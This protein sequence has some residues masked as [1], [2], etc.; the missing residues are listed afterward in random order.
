MSL[1]VRESKLVKLAT[2][3]TVNKKLDGSLECIKTTGETARTSRQACKIMSEFSVTRF[4]GIGVSLA[5]R[6]S[7]LGWIVNKC[8]VNTEFVTEILIRRWAIIYNGLKRFWRP[9]FYQ[10]PG[11]ITTG[12]AI[13]FCD[14]VE[15]IFFFSMN[16][17]N[18]SSSAVSTV[19]GTDALGN[20]AV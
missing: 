8:F 4:N 3:E 16:V 12:F 14:D 19:S 1:I 17:N 7:V 2:V 15:D 5:F 18:S 10:V 13:Y 6:K 20:V 11:Q 9:L